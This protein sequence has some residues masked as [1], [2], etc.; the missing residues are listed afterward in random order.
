MWGACQGNHFESSYPASFACV[1]KTKSSRFIIIVD[2][3]IGT[4]YICTSVCSP[5]EPRSLSI[6]ILLHD[7]TGRRWDFYAYSSIVSS[8]RTLYSSLSNQVLS[9]HCTLLLQECIKARAIHIH[10]FEHSSLMKP[11]FTHYSMESHF[12]ICSDILQSIHALL[13]N[14]KQLIISTMK[15]SNPFCNEVLLTLLS[16]LIVVWMDSTNDFLT[17][18]HYCSTIA[19]CMLCF[20]CL[21][22][23]CWKC[24]WIP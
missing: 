14:N 18:L 11:L 13:R 21:N 9:A 5:S 4:K 15:P 23:R 16:Q 20:D 22:R 6:H 2:W 19:C 10:L 3:S 8:N 24:S 1:C 12:D 7:F 17:K